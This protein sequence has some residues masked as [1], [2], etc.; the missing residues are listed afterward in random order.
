MVDLIIEIEGHNFI[1]YFVFPLFLSILLNYNYIAV[2]V[3]HE[4]SN[5]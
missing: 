1:V 3:G 5:F 2:C 4:K